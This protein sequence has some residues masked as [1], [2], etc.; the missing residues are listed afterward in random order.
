[1]IG[2][3]YF[4]EITGSGKFPHKLLAEQNCFPEKNNDAVTAFERAGSNRTIRMKSI[5]PPNVDLWRSYGWS[6][7]VLSLTTPP[8]DYTLYHTW[9]C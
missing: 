1:M 5:T 4:F 2:K 9:P 8:E 3:T 6:I 7:H